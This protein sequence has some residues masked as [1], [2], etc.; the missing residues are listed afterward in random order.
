MS[1]DDGAV[2]IIGWDPSLVRETVA[3]GLRPVLVRDVPAH[4]RG[5]SIPLPEETEEIVVEDIT[6]VGDV[7]AGLTR[8][9]GERLHQELRGIV[10]FDE[11]AVSTV[12][13]LTS[14][15]NLPGSR[16]ERAVLMRDKHLQK[17]AVLAAG[18]PAAASRLVVPGSERIRT[19]F[20]GPCV[21]KPVAGG[22]TAHTEM[23]RTEAE[24]EA[25]LNKLALSATSPFVVEDLVDVAQE[26]I[27]DG[28]MQ[29]G[30]VVFSSVGRYAAPCLS[31]TTDAEPLHIYRVDGTGE[32]ER[33]AEARAF[34][35]KALQALGYTD[36]VFH[37]ELLLD[38]SSDTFFFG[39]VAARVG[40]CLIQEAV[41]LKHDFSLAGGAVDVALGRPVQ[42]TSET[43]DRCVATTSLHLPR[44]TVVR[45]PN[46][47][48]FAAAD[49][50][51]EVRVAVLLG[52]NDHPEVRATTNWQGLALVSA[53]SLAELDARMAAVRGEFIEQSLVAPT[54]GTGVQQRAFLADYEDAWRRLL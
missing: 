30:V 44:G 18:V 45:L 10:T 37:L 9:F 48:R 42:S 47:G 13:A 22:G 26:W 17:Q 33:C 11:F 46:S 52:V 4:L 41:L 19:P 15:M 38:R 2:A 54:F 8:H 1:V 5:T 35:G 39:E 43:T 27:V 34:A 23:V 12:A 28:V 31:Y 21:V 20:P 29:D 40:G 32:D 25:L 6:D 51:H 53:A 24:Y 14:L 16:L 3:R 50:I 7:W 36:G 49:D